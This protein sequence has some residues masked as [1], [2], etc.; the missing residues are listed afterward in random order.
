[1]ARERYNHQDVEKKWQDV[2]YASDAFTAADLT[3][4]K[5]AYILDMFPYPSGDGLHVGHPEGY[6]ASD[7]FCRYLRMTGTNVLHPMGWDA[8]GLPAENYAIKT[9][10]HPAET[11]KV[12]IATFKRQIQSLG[13]SYDWSREV[14]TTDPEYY[15]WTQWIFLKLF[16]HGLAYEAEAPINWCPKDKTGLANEEVV[17]G[18][19]DRCGTVV[20]K[21]NI[22]QWLV[23]ITDAKY[24]E[25]LLN[26]LDA[27][28]WPESIKQSQ[29]NWIGKREGANITFQLKGISEQ[30][31]GKHSVQ[32]FTTRPDTICGATFLVVSPELAQQWLDVGWKAPSKVTTYVTKAFAASD[33][34]RQNDTKGK[35]GV[36]T[37]IRAVNPASGEEIPV[38]VA[39]Y[40]LGSYGTGAIMAVPAHDERDFAFAKKYKL[41]VV[42]VIAPHVIDAKN[43]PQAGKPTVAR[44]TIQAIIYNAKTKKYLTL[45]W[46]HQPWQTFVVGGVDADE[47]I[48]EAAK[49]E[50]REETGY[51]DVRLERVLGGP[52]YAEYYAA[53]KNENRQAMSYPILFTLHSNKCEA[54]SAEEQDKHEVE[55]LTLEE[56]HNTEM[57]CSELPIWLERLRGKDVYTGNGLMI[58]SGENDYLT[59]EVFCKKIVAWLEKEAKGKA[60]TNYKLRDW[61]FSRQRYW[62]EPVPIVH[63]PKDG[64]VGVPEEQLPVVLPDVKKYEP[65][66]TGE[67]PLANIQEWVNTTCPKCGGPAKRETNT[68]PQWAG[69][70]WYFLRYCDPHNTKQLADPEK[71]K[72]WLPVDTYIGGAEHAVLHLLYARFIYKFLHDI[73][74]VPK[75]LPDEPF[76]K[77]INQGLIL[78]EDGQKMSKSRGNVINPDLVVR[79]Y[80]ADSLRMFEMFMG[81]LEDVKPW[82]TRGIVGVR[83]FLDRIWDLCQ[84]NPLLSSD[85]RSKN[86]EGTWELSGISNELHSA[87]NRTI[88]KVTEDIVSFQFNTAVSELMIFSR[89]AQNNKV[90]FSIELKDVF[91]KLLSPF[92]PHIA[93]ELWEKLG[94]ADQVHAHAWPTFDAAKVT[95]ESVEVVVQINGK[96]RDK[97]TVATGVDEEHMKAQALASEKIQKWLAGNAPKKV[98][99]VKGKLVSIVV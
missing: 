24:I 9:G 82:N 83:R 2:W 87:L 10:T 61:V 15:K 22:R 84:A 65:T 44:K 31:D 97:F 21:K 20:E 35:T 80:G 33:I 7:I 32:V 63:C 71:L 14:N 26:D 98:F 37:G 86:A 75:E 64:N 3:K 79:E 8:F 6:T 54:V 45:K 56:I 52:V 76:T 42:A 99:V 34:D 77:L 25:R 50:I 13:F 70:N 4:T 94:H 48:V 51:V 17:G 89:A 16:E 46:K 69:S 72:V 5:K 73:G 66:G 19:C 47:D 91:I 18:K 49:R 68:M 36:D 62:G 28:D 23:K 95:A 12:N 55:W 30:A 60:A 93:Q 96:V 43:P 88:K 53:H 40:V 67:S 57:A 27:L 29:R 92:A 1:M 81:P 74:S 90:F 58:N 85:L 41:P 11:T 59:S 39:D 78:A 38:W